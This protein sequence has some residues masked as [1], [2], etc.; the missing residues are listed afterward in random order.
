[1]WFRKT[2]LMSKNPCELFHK[3]FFFLLTRKLDFAKSQWNFNL[4]DL[5]FFQILKSLKL[6]AVN[7]QEWGASGHMAF[8]ILNSLSIQMAWTP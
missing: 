5:V 8:V 4:K 7:E 6:V 2:H 1:M 3:L